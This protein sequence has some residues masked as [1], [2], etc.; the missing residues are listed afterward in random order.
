MCY[1]VTLKCEKWGFLL[2]V[3]TASLLTLCPVAGAVLCPSFHGL[4]SN[5]MVKA[6]CSFSKASFLHWAGHPGRLL[7]VTCLVIARDAESKLQ[8]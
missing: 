5:D 3:L 7:A 4:C 1:L 6:S 8:A 2:R